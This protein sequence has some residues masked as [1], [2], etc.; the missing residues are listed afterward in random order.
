MCNTIIYDYLSDLTYIVGSFMLYC[1]LIIQ[2]RF[3]KLIQ[4]L[5]SN[6]S[7]IEIGSRCSANEGF[8]NTI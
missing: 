1:F 6:L 4:Y 7:I 2:I 5:L 8:V 3:R